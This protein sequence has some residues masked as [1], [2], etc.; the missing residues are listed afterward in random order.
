M[1]NFFVYIVSSN[2]KRI[3]IGMTNDLDRRLYEH[4]HKLIKGFTAKYNM[5][6]LVYY[7]V[8]SSVQQAIDRE[9]QLKGWLRERKINLIESLNPSWK[10]LSENW[11]LDQ[12]DS[13]LRPN[14]PMAEFGLRS[15]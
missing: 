15:E 2:S 14:P 8:F 3:Y 12:R 1:E 5:D 4:K 7:E 9:T 10:D 13:S 6:K 11:Q